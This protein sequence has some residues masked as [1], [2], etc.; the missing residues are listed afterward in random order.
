ML[1]FTFTVPWNLGKKEWHSEWA[2]CRHDI[3]GQWVF[4]CCSVAQHTVSK[5][6]AHIE[7]F[8]IPQEL[9]GSN[10][11]SSAPVKLVGLAEYP[12][13]LQ[14]QIE[15]HYHGRTHQNQ[16]HHHSGW[17]AWKPSSLQSVT[18]IVVVSWMDWALIFDPTR[19][20][21]SLPYFWHFMTM[22]LSA[23]LVLTFQYENSHFFQVTPY[24]IYRDD[25]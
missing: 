10:Y 24:N 13:L 22:E 23:S 25:L 1:L 19:L 9:H 8:S 4:F 16:I 3:C 20:Q 11:I 6:G 14:A 21:L 2:Y 5:L 12:H 18:R 17:H 15:P 7:I